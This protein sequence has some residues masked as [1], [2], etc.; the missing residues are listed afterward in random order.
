LG[1]SG[2]GGGVAQLAISAMTTTPAQ[3]HLL[4]YLRRR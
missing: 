2:G 1:G 4:R 3:C